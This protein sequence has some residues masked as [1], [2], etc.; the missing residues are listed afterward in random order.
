MPPEVLG[1]IAALVEERQRAGVAAAYSVGMRVPAPCG[2]RN[3]WLVAF[4]M[5][6]FSPLYVRLAQKTSIELT[7][8]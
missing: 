5:V 7:T 1:G 4:A 3:K 8:S 6:D 2:H